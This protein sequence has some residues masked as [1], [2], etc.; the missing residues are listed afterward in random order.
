MH[1]DLDD[2]V[3]GER[4]ELDITAVGLH[5]WADEVQDF[6]HALKDGVAAHGL[7]GGGRLRGERDG[8]GWVKSGQDVEV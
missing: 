6:L 4:D 5:R 1:A 8:F 3:G 7:R 2:V